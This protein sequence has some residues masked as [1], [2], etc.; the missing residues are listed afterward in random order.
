[1]SNLH[2]NFPDDFATDREKEKYS[3]GKQVGEAICAQWFNGQL[4]A[5]R[6]WISK[7]RAYS[8]GEQKTDYKSIIEGSRKNGKVGIKTHKIDYSKK[9]K[10]MPVFKDIIVNAID[11]SLFKP[12][13]EAI[14][15]SAINEKKNYFNR[16]E[17]DFYTQDFN[18]II[19][20]GIGV[21]V[22]PQDVAK[23]ENELNVKK[24]EFKPDIEIAQELAIENV[25]K[26][27]RIE[28]I[29][30]K[31]DE[32]LFDLGF[33]VGMHYTDNAEGIKLKY[34]DPFNYI[35]STFQID[36]GRD[37]R[38][39]GEAD[40]ATIASI[41]NM[42]DRKLTD[43]ELLAIKN[44]ALQDYSNIQAYD[45][46]E[47]G[48][49]MI[50]YFRFTYKVSK[51]RVFK[52]LNKNK[53]VRLIDRSYDD[54]EYNPKN[55]NKK[56][57]IAHNVWYEGVFIPT[58]NVIIKWK[59]FPNQVELETNNPISPY[60]IYAPK[61]KRNSESGNVRFDSMIERAI[62]IIDDIQIDWYKLRQLK[63]E[64]RP[65][66]TEINID[67]ISN[68]T[69]NNKKIAP[70]DVL[71]L[72]FGR[73]IMLKKSYDEEGDPIERAVREEASPVNYSALSFLAGEFGNNLS[74]LRQLTGINELRDG[75]TKPNSRTSATVQKL[76]LAS[77]NNST[78]HIVKGSFSISLRFAQGVS[79]RLIDVLDSK[80]L[81][82]MYMNIIGTDNVD[83]LNSIKKIPMHV[84]GIYFDFE[85]DNDER[86]AFEQS[87]IT[88]LNKG[89]IN[90]A[91]YNKARQ[92]R[93]VK[94]AIKYLET[95]IEE[96]VAK[97]EQRK[98][99]NSQ[100]QA[101]ANAQS[102]VVAEQAR[103]QTATIA[104]N[105]K[106][107]EMLLQDQINERKEKRKALLDNALDAEKH[108]RKKEIANIEKSLQM[109]KIKFI[110][111]EKSRRIDQASTNESAKIEQR[112]EKKP[113]IDF[114]NR[115]SDILNEE[116]P[117]IN[118]A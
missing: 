68:I 116:I 40:E 41:I 107:Q 20:Q 57:E 89:E 90:S 10:I 85:P 115:V 67:A 93:N 79:L 105:I 117:N 1:M 63:S 30:D 23:S 78:N 80:N 109:D 112:Q 44:Y 70:Q 106:K 35:H 29:K 58:A 82:D 37:K 53:S 51:S 100:A 5:R 54:V 96:N 59:P 81:R 8:K 47:D 31:V 22:S 24:L 25:F 28:S 86:I 92:V 108:E 76:L 60:V 118:E 33:G 62:P 12:R 66:T 65:N 102:S 18:N 64:L 113:K 56:L 16:I 50:E 71:D 11:E 110:E 15:I 21:N 95:V 39:D 43:D 13:A 9:L 6:K 19:S 73:G 77:S 48:H 61:V 83:L 69:L 114:E 38:Y 42:A 88:S 87:L 75:T 32:D 45:E 94:S 91:Q 14:D 4:N 99:A 27:Q 17:N 3:Y 111:D 74:R 104:W 84:F 97:A 103:Q 7:M 36:D 49:R 98:I 46:S 26:H 34:I 2:G 52:R 101:Q 72:F 55:K